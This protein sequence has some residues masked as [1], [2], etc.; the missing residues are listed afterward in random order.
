MHCFMKNYQ[1]EFYKD[2][3]NIKKGKESFTQVIGDVV[4][5]VSL[6]EHIWVKVALH[7]LITNGSS[8]VN[9]CRQNESSN[10]C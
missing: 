1:N 9:G 7:Y 2:R 3:L 5:F 4:K 10:G 8:V 6:S